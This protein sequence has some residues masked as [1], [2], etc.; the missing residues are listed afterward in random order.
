MLQSTVEE[1]K[2]CGNC[3]HQRNEADSIFVGLSIR[4]IAEVQAKK[5]VDSAQ[6]SANT[7]NH[8]NRAS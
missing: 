8:F 2:Y 6:S 1:G 7:S 4:M 3:P 5:P